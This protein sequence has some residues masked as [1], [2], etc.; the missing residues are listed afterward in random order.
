MW[1]TFIKGLVFVTV[2]VLFVSTAYGF[3]SSRIEISREKFVLPHLNQKLRIVA[4]SDVHAPSFYF[5]NSELAR[6]INHES[7]DIFILA[8]DIVDSPGKEAM[9]RDF[10]MVN[11]RTSKLAVLG[12][13]EY[14]SELYIPKLKVEYANAGIILLINDKVELP[15][16][17][18][19]GFDDLIGGAPDY[20]SLQQI[21][22]DSQSLLM[23]SHCPQVFDILFTISLPPTLVLSGHT[24]GGQI[25]PFGI[26]IL[27]P[28]GS[29]QYVKG[30]YHKGEHSM[31]VMRGIG[32]TPGIP[33]RM[34]VRPEILV[35]DLIPN[36]NVKF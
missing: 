36:Q 31:Y 14:F 17:T 8:G 28:K 9:V 26:T 34:G 19:V 27:T 25:S 23:I 6:L 3:R 4:I 22:R 11:A 16:L 29:G 35:L 2:V 10:K 1:R 32:T 30:W 20:S 33:L 18:L 7:P 13:W 21:F 15:G 12:N 24:H 5:S